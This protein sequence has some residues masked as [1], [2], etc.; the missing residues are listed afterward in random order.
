MVGG[1]FLTYTAC[2]MSF[3]DKL[4]AV[5]DLTRYREY[6]GVTTASTTLGVLAWSNP[7]PDTISTVIT[8]LLMH[9]C[10]FAFAFMI[11]D[12]E[13]ATDDALDKEKSARNPISS[14]RLS[15]MLGLFATG[16]V[17]CTS[18][19]LSTL[20]GQ[21]VLLANFFALVLAFMYSWRWIRLK[22]I[23][24]VDVVSHALFLG[25]LQY[26]AT[27]WAHPTTSVPTVVWG[28]LSIF[29]VSVTGDLHN[30]IRD[31][32]VDRV[33]GLRN[34]VQTLCLHRYARWIPGL[35]ICAYSVVILYFIF[36]A[37]L[38]SV[39]VMITIVM[40]MILSLTTIQLMRISMDYSYHHR[41][42]MLGFFGT[43]IMVMKILG[44]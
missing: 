21:A 20:L 39:L 36:H 38:A 3:T 10:T 7:T 25:T 37:S 31:Y 16:C 22:S 40:L 8:L 33:A 42:T 11:N 29:A 9:F 35:Q 15:R 24:F 23:P 32:D 27:V 28:A 19:V 5:A 14:G 30:E 34:T 26:L 2:R 44:I 17:A 1:W 43:I 13:D 6:L 18:I 4:R 41:E 12:I